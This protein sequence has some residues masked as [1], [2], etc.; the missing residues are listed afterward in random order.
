M[1][2]GLSGFKTLAQVFTG[3][4]DGENSTQ[5][6]LPKFRG[7]EEFL[8]LHNPLLEHLLQSLPDLHFIAVDERTVNVPVSG[9]DGFFHGRCN[10]SLFRKPSSKE[11]KK[12]GKM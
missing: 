12:V 3:R 6:L 9:P 10:Q 7:D 2:G 4:D 5:W 11:M 1:R 8:P